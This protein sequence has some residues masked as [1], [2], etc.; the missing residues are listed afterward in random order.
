MKIPMKKSVIIF[1]S[2]I[3]LI[4]LFVVLRPPGPPKLPANSSDGSNAV[5]IPGAWDIKSFSDTKKNVATPAVNKPK[6]T[7]TKP[8]RTPKPLPYPRIVI[9]YSMQKTRS[10]GSNILDKNSWFIIVTLDIRNYGYKYFDAHPS[11]FRIGK[12]G[13]IIP[14]INISTGKTIDAVIPNNSRARGNLIFLL[15]KKVSQ[16]KLIYSPTSTP[17][18]Y[19]IIYKKLSLREMEETKQEV[20]DA[21]NEGT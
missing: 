21:D 7:T 8:K 5:N 13:D 20:F 18:N 16:G 9:N 10:I 2:L 17:E 1:A 14:L 6:T 12:G 11:K 3:V 19:Y 15:G 4:V